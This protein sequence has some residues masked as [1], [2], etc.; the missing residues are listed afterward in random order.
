MTDFGRD[1]SCASSLRSGR[2]VTGALLVGEACYRRLSTRRGTLRGPARE[3]DYGLPLHE[4]VGRTGDL[5]ALVASLPGRIRAELVKDERVTDGT[6]T[7]S[8][9]T[10]GPSTSLEIAIVAYTT[11]GPV[12]LTV[13]VSEVSV[14]LLTLSPGG[15]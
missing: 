11:S 15:G 14:E 9:V 7:V 12:V 8:R 3:G 10:S 4:L 2:I 1:T 5:A 13:A 6:A